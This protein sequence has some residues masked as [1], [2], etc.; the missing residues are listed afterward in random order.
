MIVNLGLTHWRGKGGESGVSETF[1][2]DTQ[3][4]AGTMQAGS[5][6]RLTEE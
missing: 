3:L 4:V 2:L 5:N 6:P 1:G